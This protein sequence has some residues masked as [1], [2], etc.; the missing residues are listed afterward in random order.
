MLSNK[1]LFL[2]DKKGH[3]LGMDVHDSSS[4]GYDRPLVPGSVSKSKLF[5]VSSVR[6]L[7]VHLLTCLPSSCINKLNYLDR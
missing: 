6:G 2:M 5:Q 4:V 1:V 7:H 3:Y